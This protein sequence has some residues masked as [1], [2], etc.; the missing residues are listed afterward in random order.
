MLSHNCNKWIYLECSIECFYCN[1]D[2]ASGLV[3][4]FGIYWRMC[5]SL[6]YYVAGMVWSPHV[7]MPA[8][9][10][11]WAPKPID[12]RPLYGLPMMVSTPQQ[13]E[14][15]DLSASAQDVPLRNGTINGETSVIAPNPIN[16][17]KRVVGDVWESTDCVVN[18]SKPDKNQTSPGT[19]PGEKAVDQ[20]LKNDSL[21][22][23]RL[24]DFNF[25]VKPVT[26]CDEQTPQR[27]QSE[28]KN[29]C[30]PK[31]S[32]VKEAEKSN[33]SHSFLENSY[34]SVDTD[35]SRLVVAESSTDDIFGIS[36]VQN[37]NDLTSQVYEKS[38]KSSVVI[39]TVTSSKNE[40]STL[41]TLS[42]NS[43][44]SENSTVVISSGI[45]NISLKATQI[46][47]G[48]WQCSSKS[49]ISLTAIQ[50]E[51]SGPNPSVENVEILLESMFNS[52]EET[53]SSQVS[54]GGV[55]QSVIVPNGA[56]TEPCTPLTETIMPMKE[57]EL[58]KTL[59]EDILPDSKEESLITNIKDESE[60]QTDIKDLLD[61]VTEEP[62]IVIVNIV[63]DQPNTV[64]EEVNASEL[65]N[66]EESK[67]NVESKHNTLPN[68][69]TGTQEIG[70]E[71]ED[72]SMSNSVEKCMPSLLKPCLSSNPF[73]EVESELEKM[74][75]GIVEGGSSDTLGQPLC[76]EPN[77]LATNK[78]P[79]RKRKKT[80]TRR[81]SDNSFFDGS[82][83][84]GIPLRKKCRKS[85]SGSEKGPKK[86]KMDYYDGLKKGKLI[87]EMGSD[88]FSSKVKGPFVHI[89]GSK[90]SPAN[91]VVVNSGSRG[92]DEEIGEKPSARWKHSK[93]QK[94]EGNS[95]IILLR[96]FIN[97]V[98]YSSN[99]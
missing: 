3:L 55:S 69:V 49:E 19:I 37:T 98:F 17:S 44:E 97:T 68:C 65:E 4:L 9:G 85:A 74:F 2:F 92:D 16:C 58:A 81:H 94:R 75:A 91:V 57:E 23:D 12:S 7:G 54:A 8:R 31:A 39:P 41:L 64:K 36:P 53:C 13:E 43:A 78:K 63:P 80:N 79:T 45:E 66:R 6:T 34:L 33:E 27:L 22:L 50:Q 88:V 73:I 26:E 18:V 47:A 86:L 59:A 76:S 96:F 30:D 38:E 72:Q 83:G 51:S 87:K 32:F 70:C 21:E 77:K 14:T 11:M 15:M 5:N 71:F 40:N 89:E 90:E 28:H 29:D 20:V 46:A 95:S 67:L 61:S 42:G 35:E 48:L 60:G 52:Q 24:S 99:K 84:E 93:H 56:N 25:S 10:Q 1:I 82:S 62:K